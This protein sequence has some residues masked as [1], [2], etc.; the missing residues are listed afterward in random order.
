MASESGSS[1]INAGYVTR[2]VRLYVP[3]ATLREMGVSRE[4]LQERLQAVLDGLSPEELDSILDEI[5][6]ET[7]ANN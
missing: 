3:K 2:Q 7:A 1:P 4:A 5:R 6:D